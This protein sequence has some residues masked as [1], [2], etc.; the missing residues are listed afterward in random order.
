LFP[1]VHICFAADVL[2]KLNNEIILGAVFPDTVIAGYLGHPDTHRR[3]GE[4]YEYLCGLGIF[5]DFAEA[6]VT[7]GI[8]PAGL[9]YYCD[10]KYLNFAKGYAFEAA[11]PLVGK[12]I[13]CCR[14]PEKMGF[15]KAHNF[16]EMAAD[17]WF[18]ERRKEY[19]GYLARALAS[20]DLI[21]ALS[22]VLA[23]FYELPVGKMAMSFPIYGEYVTIDNMTP[24]ELAKK[25]GRQTAKKHGI[26]I[27][28]P[29]AANVI[30]E[31]LDIVDRT[32]PEFLEI[33]K[34]RV[35]SLIKNLSG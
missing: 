22:Q 34:E 17:L 35:G 6:A 28:V 3:C 25:Y 1:Y 26:N 31:A 13:K 20:E 30:E 15:W 21:L 29:A 8:T 9:D 24:L 2:G 32:F 14:L 4:I 12:V 11:R 23:P 10:E 16:I 7:H 19:R 27:D 5:K 33:S 18:Y